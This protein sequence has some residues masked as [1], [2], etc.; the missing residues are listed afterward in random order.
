LDFTAP[1][2]L[3]QM[4]T[5]VGGLGVWVQIASIRMMA[6]LIRALRDVE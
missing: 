5:L 4:M 1:L 3:W 2:S 6:H